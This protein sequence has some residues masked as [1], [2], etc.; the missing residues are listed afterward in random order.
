LFEDAGKF[1]ETLYLGEEHELSER[2]YKLGKG[3]FFMDIF[4]Y[5]Y[6]RRIEK[7]GTYRTLFKDIIS[8]LHRMFI[9]K[10][11]FKIY[12]KRYGHY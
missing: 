7:E 5:N 6:P 10:I 11:N 3:K 9:G 1:D 8:E 2:L 12:E 4:A